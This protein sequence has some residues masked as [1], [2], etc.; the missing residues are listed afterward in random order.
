MVVKARAAA[1][2][3]DRKGKLMQPDIRDRMLD[4][5][6]HDAEPGS[7]LIYHRG[8]LARDKLHDPR[9][10]AVAERMLALSNG[11]FDIVSGCG[12]V[13]GEIVGSKQVELLTK[14]ERGETLYI[15]ERRK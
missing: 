14:K 2:E 5:W 6:L 3:Q 4:R 1:A 10:S 15:A 7:R 12:H 13:R 9:L 8:E 11:R